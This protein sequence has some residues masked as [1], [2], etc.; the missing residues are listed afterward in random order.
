MK[1]NTPQRIDYLVA[2]K[3][4]KGDLE[5]ADKILAWVEE[6]TKQNEA[7]AKLIASAPELLEA[8]QWIEHHAL[9]DGCSKEV[10]K[11]VA[12]QAIKK[13]TT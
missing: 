2:A 3:I 12:L 9:Q 8:L 1:A 11:G 7:N 10:L 4:A 13:A 5:K 6:R